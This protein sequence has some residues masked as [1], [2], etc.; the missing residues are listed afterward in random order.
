[1]KNRGLTFVKSTNAY[2]NHKK[3]EAYIEQLKLEQNIKNAILGGFFA[4]IIGAALWAL[5]TVVTEFQIGYMSIGVGA[6]VG[7][8]VRV[9]GKGLDSIF[10][11]IG[12]FFALLGCILGN[13]L[14]IVAFAAAAEGYTF[15][16]FLGLIDYSVVPQVMLDSF[17]VMDVLFY[18]LALGAGYKF[19]LRV[20]SEEEILDITK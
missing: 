2:S 15:F 3:I 17:Q 6:L 1:M 4:S 5:I 12:A 11:F 7:F 13:F 9:F 8:G 14:S 19:S 20:L 10:G 18:A 16:Q